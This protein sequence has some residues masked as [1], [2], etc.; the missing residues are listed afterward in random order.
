MVMKDISEFIADRDEAI[1]SFDRYKIETFCKKYGIFMPD[2]D[3][4]FWLGICESILSVPNAPDEAKSKAREW[5][6]ANYRG[7][8]IYGGGYG[9]E[10]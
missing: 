1:F 2:S 9:Q 6:R 3:W 5:I 10:A 7:E 4:A 8:Y